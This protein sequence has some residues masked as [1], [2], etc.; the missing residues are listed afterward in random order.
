MLPQSKK[1]RLFC[2]QAARMTVK[3][4]GDVIMGEIVNDKRYHSQG[5][6]SVEDLRSVCSCTCVTC[7]PNFFSRDAQGRRKRSLSP[8][9]LY[10]DYYQTPPRSRPESVHEIRSCE[11][12]NSDYGLLMT[13]LQGSTD[14]SQVATISGTSVNHASLEYHSGP[15]Q[16][17]M[18][19]VQAAIMFRREIPTSETPSHQI[20]YGEKT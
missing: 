11:Y 17:V 2:F 14:I 13:P 18:V 12:S 6:G 5:L 1:L 4:D 8:P 7:H 10:S 9:A 19:G 16:Q 20:D 15:R 3:L